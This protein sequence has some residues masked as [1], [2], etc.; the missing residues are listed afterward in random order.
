MVPAP[1]P[2]AYTPR[3]LH[4]QEQAQKQILLNEVPPQTRSGVE[5]NYLWTIQDAE[6]S[7]WML[8]SRFPNGFWYFRLFHNQSNELN[9][10]R[11][12]LVEVLRDVGQGKAFRFTSTIH[13]L[14]PQVTQPIY[15]GSIKRRDFWSAAK[16]ERRSE[17]VLR[18]Y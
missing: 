10:V 2:R 15:T 1:S 14:E 16:D 9:Q 3:H 17:I 7:A 13:V 6:T 12:S 5:A 11:G 4:A 18:A 8:V